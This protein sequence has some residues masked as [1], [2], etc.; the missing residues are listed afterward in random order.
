MVTILL[1]AVF[2][3]ANRGEEKR[4][5]EVIPWKEREREGKRKRPR[6]VKAE[7]PKAENPKL[8]GGK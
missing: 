4:K 8:I 6:P 7:Q 1:I 5:V 3:E 2:R